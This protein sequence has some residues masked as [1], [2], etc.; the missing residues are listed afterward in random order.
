MARIFMTHKV[1]DYDS[2]KPLYDADAERRAGAGLTEGGH[3]HSAADRNTFLIIWD[4]D[5]G[6]DEARAIV[7]GMMNDP[8]LGELMKEA[9]VLEKP[10]AWIA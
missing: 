4:H 5:G 6:V 7:D 2:W 3:F 10:A 1:A 8:G 9:G